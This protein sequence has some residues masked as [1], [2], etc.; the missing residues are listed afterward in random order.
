MGQTRLIA[1]LP[2]GT[3]LNYGATGGTGNSAS[4]TN[5]D[6]RGVAIT[7]KNTAGAGTSPTLTVKLQEQFSGAG[8]VDVA[9]ATTAAI[10]AGTPATTTFVLYPGVTVAANAGVSRPLAKAWRLFYTI[11]G[12]AT[13]T[14]TCSIDAALLA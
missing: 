14:V 6:C 1:V 4:Y 12:T 7:V 3:V 11:G 2:A 10:A 13:P 9:G 8:W 5:R